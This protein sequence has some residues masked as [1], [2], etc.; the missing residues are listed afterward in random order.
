VDIQW[1]GTPTNVLFSFWGNSGMWSYFFTKGFIHDFDSLDHS[2]Q[3]I[4]KKRIEQIIREP[5]NGKELLG[6][7]G[8]YRE[9]FLNFRIV[10]RLQGNAIAFMRLKNRKQAYS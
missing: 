8:L 2:I 9:R 4:A 6:E 1:R 3:V 5:R 7:P 10:Y